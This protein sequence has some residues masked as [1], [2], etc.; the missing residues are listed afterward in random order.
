[1]F[2]EEF[3]MFV[4]DPMFHGALSWSSPLVPMIFVLF[5]FM[6]VA[7]FVIKFTYFGSNSY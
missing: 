1:M 3:E 7:Y 4:L 6:P 2:A 5:I